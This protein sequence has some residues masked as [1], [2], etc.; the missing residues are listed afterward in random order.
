MVALKSDLLRAGLKKVTYKL[1]NAVR[2]WKFLAGSEVRLLEC[3]DLKGK[4]PHLVN[5]EKFTER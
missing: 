2:L 1:R 3:K 5:R 4:T